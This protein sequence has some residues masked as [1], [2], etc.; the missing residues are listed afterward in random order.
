MCQEIVKRSEVLHAPVL[1]RSHFTQVTAKLQKFRVSV[2]FDGLLPLENGFNFGE[3]KQRAL[4]TQLRRESRLFS[5]QAGQS[6][7]ARLLAFGVASRQREPCCIDKV[8]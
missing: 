5:N 1:T 6:N 8:Q 3:D 7:Q 2:A 4:T